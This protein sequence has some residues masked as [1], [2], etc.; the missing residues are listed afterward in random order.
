MTGLRLRSAELRDDES[1]LTLIELLVSATMGVILFAA[2]ASLMVSAMRTQPELSKRAQTI[3]TARWVMERLTREIRN[4]IAV[5]PGKATASEVSF[6]TY[7]RAPSC[8]GSGTL[9]SSAKAIPCQVTYR[10]TTGK[11]ARVEAAPGVYTGTEITIFDGISNSSV[12]SYT[13]S[14]T[15]AKFIEVKLKFPN[16]TGEGDL[17]IS[18]GASLRNANLL[19]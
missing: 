8:G 1:G 16:P 9:A 18:D 17:T 14:A 5:A 3:S 6:T 10:C 11:C 15:E 13:P 12:F 4:G 7:V 2:A 19:N